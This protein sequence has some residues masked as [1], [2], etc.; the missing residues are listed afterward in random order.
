[1]ID[2]WTKNP[3]VF[4]FSSAISQKL[5][6]SILSV[7][8]VQIFFCKVV[9]TIAFVFRTRFALIIETADVNKSK[10]YACWLAGTRSKGT[11]R[12]RHKNWRNSIGLEIIKMAYLNQAQTNIQFWK[13]L[14]SEI[15]NHVNQIANP[16]MIWDTWHPDR[17]GIGDCLFK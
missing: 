7:T 8:S 10:S 5:I 17:T 3:N 12:F 16:K 14:V 15:K 4:L 6:S 11:S 9:K 13:K 1:M 2:Y